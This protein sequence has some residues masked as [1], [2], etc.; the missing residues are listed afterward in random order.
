MRRARRVQ[1]L[2]A[3]LLKCAVSEPDSVQDMVSRRAAIRKAWLPELSI[4]RAPIATRL[5]SAGSATG[6]EFG[7]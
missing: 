3:M 4:V 1:D 6:S 5:E 2:H 7:C